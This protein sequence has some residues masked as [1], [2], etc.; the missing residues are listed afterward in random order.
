MNSESPVPA[1]GGCVATLARVSLP[2]G[3]LALA[4]CTPTLDWRAV[5]LPDTEL[6]ADMPC[7]P[8]RFQRDVV[9]ADTPLKD[10]KSVV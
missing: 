2:L 6:V 4:A 10:R 1:I 9:V 3:L 5:R 8:G 7:R